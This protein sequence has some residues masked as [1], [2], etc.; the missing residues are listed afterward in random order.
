M[1]ILGTGL[2]P[3][4]IP[5]EGGEPPVFGVEAFKSR[6][7][8]NIQGMEWLNNHLIQAIVAA[9][10]VI[11]FW[12]WVARKQSVVPSKRQHLG[13]FVYDLVRNTIARDTMGAD[14]DKY[15][16]IVMPFLLTFFSFIAVNN[17]FGETFFF[18]FPTFSKIGYAYALGITAWLLYNGL[19]MMRHG[20]FG[21]LKHA[22]I[23]AGVPWPMWIL[24]IPIEFL[25]NIVLRPI[26]L[27]LRL[28]ANLFA[29]HLV[30]M[31]FVVGGGFLVEH[32]HNPMMFGGGVVAL[33]LSIAVFALE[34]LVAV[35]QAYVFTT[36][37]SSYIASAVASEH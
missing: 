34:L 27:A 32:L 16:M 19:G 18:M 2:T 37:T 28:F 36:L 25:S 7:L 6:P 21:Y 23:P 33:I 30:V 4:F 24:I 12:L 17:L 3:M 22:T 13:E 26:T 14:F 11:V 1:S 8:F 9:L 5:L 35:L 31:V 29:G 20:F 15:K 10:I